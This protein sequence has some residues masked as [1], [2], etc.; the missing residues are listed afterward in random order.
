MGAAA[1]QPG[2]QSRN[3]PLSRLSSLRDLVSRD[4]EHR[5][6]WVGALPATGTTALLVRPESWQEQLLNSVQRSLCSVNQA[7]QCPTIV[8]TTSYLSTTTYKEA[9]VSR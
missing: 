4:R 1:R 7:L 6:L 9:L 3:G 5:S 8:S 2:A